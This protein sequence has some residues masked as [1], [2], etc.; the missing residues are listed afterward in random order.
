MERTIEMYNGMVYGEKYQIMVW[1]RDIWTF[2]H[3]LE[4][5]EIVF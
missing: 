2:R 4:L 1:R 3:L 5:W